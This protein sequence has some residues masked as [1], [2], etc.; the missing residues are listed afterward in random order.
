MIVESIEYTGG[1]KHVHGQTRGT[2]VSLTLGVLS[3]SSW[4][5]RRTNP[6]SLRPVVVFSLDMDLDFS[7]MYTDTQCLFQ[8]E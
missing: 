1:Y 6:S 8:E 4:C 7:Y 2:E 5:A 3:L